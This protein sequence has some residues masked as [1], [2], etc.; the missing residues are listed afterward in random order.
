MRRHPVDQ[1]ADA[2]AVG[3]VDKAGKAFDIAEAGRGRI[4]AGGLVA[5]AGIVGMLADR[6]EFDMG[7][8]HVGDIGDQP[9]GQRVPGQEM[10]MPSRSHDPAWTS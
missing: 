10:A 7:K 1:D 5:P 8:A 6:Q 2:G 4:E 9:V 3:A